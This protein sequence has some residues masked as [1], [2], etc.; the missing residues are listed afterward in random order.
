[1]TPSCGNIG[2]SADFEVPFVSL[3]GPKPRSFD[4][5]RGGDDARGA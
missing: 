3:N 2:S 4:L 1:M 5:I